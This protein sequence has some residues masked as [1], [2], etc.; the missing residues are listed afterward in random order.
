MACQLF[1]FSQIQS[2]S[3]E[4][5]KRSVSGGSGV[6]I[7]HSHKRLFLRLPK[8][9]FKSQKMEGREIRKVKPTRF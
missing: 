8:F 7:N 1:P 2:T 6:C 3:K 9:N 4:Q 5:I